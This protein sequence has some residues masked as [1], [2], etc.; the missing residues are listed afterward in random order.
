MYVCDSQG[1]MRPVSTLWDRDISTSSDVLADKGLGMEPMRLLPERC[2]VCMYGKCVKIHAGMVPDMLLLVG[3]NG[4][5]RQVG[6]ECRPSRMRRWRLVRVHM[7][8]G[9]EPSKQ[10]LLAASVFRLYDVKGV[11]LLGIEGSEPVSMLLLT[12]SICKLVHMV[13]GG[14]VPVSLLFFSMILCMLVSLFIV[15]GIGPVRRLLCRSR[16][17]R[18]DKR[19]REGG[20][21][22][23][24]ELY[25]R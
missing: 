13:F 19:V 18:L 6:A 4:R 7:V 23:E 22:L 2:N 21:P 25:W 24:R 3:A 5:L 16:L 14:M 10:L 12:S 20:M 1:G 11:T 8:S 9:K 17:W 15:F